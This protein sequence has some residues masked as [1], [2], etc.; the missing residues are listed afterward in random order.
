MWPLGCPLRLPLPRW[1]DRQFHPML[2]SAPMVGQ[3]PTMRPAPMVGRVQEG[4]LLRA[5]DAG[6]M[7]GRDVAHALMT[8]HAA[9]R[10]T[11]MIAHRQ[12]GQG[13][14]HVPCPPMPIR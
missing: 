4:R 11:R 7:T 6:R 9:R 10:R 5:C 14:G 12:M 3:M 13:A 1:L 2:R 8:G